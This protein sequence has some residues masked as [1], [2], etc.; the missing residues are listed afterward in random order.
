MF[1]KIKFS[2]ILNKIYKSYDNQRAFADAT[3]VNRGYLSRYINKKLDSPPSPKILKG[4]ADASKGFASYD[5][6][7][8]ICGYVT[9]NQ[10]IGIKNSLINPSSDDFLVIP[11]LISE[12]GKLVHTSED[13][14]LPFKWDHIHQ[15]F[16]YKT[17]D[18]SMLPL[19]GIGDLAIIEK[20]D[21]FNNGETCLFSLDNKLYIRKILDF[22]DYLEFHTAISYTKPDKLM[23]EEKESRNFKILGKVVRAENSSAFKL[24]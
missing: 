16:A 11:I 3:G 19:L 21:S 22:K 12:N 8:Q 2:E 14:T 15:Y 13:I 6:L 20:T 10:E 9:Y 7:M 17:D 4:I 5:E 18:E 1:D 23:T 24:S